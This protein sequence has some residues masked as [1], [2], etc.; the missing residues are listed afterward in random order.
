MNMNMLQHGS[1]DACIAMADGMWKQAAQVNAMMSGA[2]MNGQMPHPLAAYAAAIGMQN[3]FGAGTTA[4]MCIPQMKRGGF[5][6]DQPQGHGADP[7]ETM[8]FSCP[9]LHRP[10]PGLASPAGLSDA[11]M[12]GFHQ[13]HQQ[14]HRK[15]DSSVGSPPTTSIATAGTASASPFE[16]AP[17]GLAA[18]APTGNG[19]FLGGRPRAASVGSESKPVESIS[20]AAAAAATAAAST[21]SK[22]G[23]GNAGAGRRKNS[24]KANGGSVGKQTNGTRFRGVRQRPWG[25]YA[26]E[27]RDPHRGT[28]VW[29]GTYDSPEEA[30]YAY[31]TAARAI[32]GANAVTNFSEPPPDIPVPQIQQYIPSF[33]V[34][35]G[36]KGDAHGG[37]SNGKKAAAAAAA[38]AAIRDGGTL[39]KQQQQ[40]APPQ[41]QAAAGMTAAGGDGG[42]GGSPAEAKSNGQD[43]PMENLSPDR[44]DDAMQ[45][46]MSSEEES[47]LTEQAEVLLMLR[48]GSSS[49]KPRRPRAMT[50]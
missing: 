27:I 26:A 29:L 20:A 40:Q 37:L 24:L 38:T 46:S 7:A 41:G 25:K 21:P 5:S 19:F 15:N 13:Q 10:H 6:K 3:Q 18:S 47:D 33:T 1:P 43:T 45:Y 32:R 16:G 42:A 23:G 14:H 34:T 17:S 28:R 35:E 48:G 44:H 4:P 12:N 30:A 11:L 2:L 36:K 39:K 9:T 8:S 50:M 49:S 22:S 31:D